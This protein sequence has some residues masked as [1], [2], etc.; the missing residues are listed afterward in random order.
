MIGKTDKS[1]QLN[2]YQVPWIQ[3][4]NKEHEL[5]QLAERIDWDG[6]DGSDKEIEQGIYI[7]RYLSKNA[8]K[9]LRIVK[10]G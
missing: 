2:M 6:L 4:I 3:F 5:Y 10:V 1:P 7:V 9:T 8:A